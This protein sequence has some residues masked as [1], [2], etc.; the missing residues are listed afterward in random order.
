MLGSDSGQYRNKIVSEVVRASIIPDREHDF[1]GKIML[2]LS[3]QPLQKVG[4]ALHSYSFA[5]NSEVPFKMLVGERG[6]KRE[7]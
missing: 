7:R 3:L 2:Y 1:V 5:D 6:R 4:M